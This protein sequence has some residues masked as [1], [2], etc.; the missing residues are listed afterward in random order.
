[1]LGYY[2]D[3]NIDIQ[4]DSFFFLTSFTYEKTSCV[5]TIAPDQLWDAHTL[6]MFRTMRKNLLWVIKNS[7]RPVIFKLRTNF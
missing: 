7:E 3:Y 2:S 1:M 5:G 6:R 4:T